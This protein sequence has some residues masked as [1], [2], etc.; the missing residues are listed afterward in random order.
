MA[1]GVL[2]LFIIGYFLVLVLISFLTTK[3][4]S[5]NDTFFVANRNSKWYLVAF[6]MIGT[7][8]SGVTFI[9]VPGKVGAPS[10]DQFA[11]FQFVLGNAAGF[12]VICLVLLPLYYRMQLTSIYGYIESALGKWSYKTAAG[13]FL[14]SR[15]IGSAFRLYLVVIILQKFIFDAYHVP[16]A[17][18][19]LICLVLIWSYTYKGG[20]KTI[21]ITDSLQTLFLVTSV[22]LSIFFI[23]RSLNLD[24][25]QAFETVK[26]SNYSKIFFLDDFT[27]SKLHFGKQFFGGMFITIA[28]VGLDQDLMQKNLSLKN[29]R[30]AQKNMFSFTSI[31]VVINLFFLSVGA[32][33]YIY[34]A[35]NNVTVAKTDYLYP[36]I[37][38]NYLGTLPA[39]VFMLGL[40]AATFATT[41]SAL[42]ALTTSFCIDFL[43]FNKRNDT[44]S[45]QM[46]A[47]RHYV[48]IAFSG[49]MF[50]TIILF[51]AINNDAVVSAIFKIASYTYGPLLGLYAFGLLLKNRQVADKL[52]PFI[53]LISPAICFFLST[54]SKR[55]LGG[56]VFDNELIIVNGLITFVGLLLTSKA[57]HK[58]AVV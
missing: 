54:E 53:C 25:I 14:V 9:S 51:N 27:G 50:L 3:N 10:G 45:K 58:I 48:H 16:F 7:A 8:L 15:T 55:L 1:P 47:M 18:T 20:L 32:L 35:Q 23:C 11:Y 41:D 52:V 29:I 38:L 43:N 44:N 17:V 28:M 31:F 49:L 13:I 34:A 33:L 40:T 4:T 46:V 26:N 57:K 22:F 19:V 2:L 56:Y 5:D 39:I 21:I 12:V 24:V 37:A 36:T 30:E 42:T 6:G